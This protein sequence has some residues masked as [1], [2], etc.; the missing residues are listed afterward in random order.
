MFSL[1]KALAS[2]YPQADVRTFVK[3]KALPENTD[4]PIREILA[5]VFDRAALIVFFASTGIAVRS[6]APFL[7]SKATDPAVLVVDEAGKYCIP[8]L[9]GHLGGGNDYAREIAQILHAEPVITTASDLMHKFAID[10]FAK[11]NHLTISSL[12]LAKDLE[13]RIIAGEDVRLF[14]DFPISGQLPDGVTLCKWRETA[15]II[16]SASAAEKDHPI[17]VEQDFFSI[18]TADAQAAVKDAPLSAKPDFFDGTTLSAQTRAKGSLHP[19][20]F[21]DMAA[22]RKESGKNP[23]DNFAEKAPDS[24]AL[25][26]IPHVLDIGI[27]S[28][29]NI[30]EAA[31][32]TAVRNTLREN[33]FFFESI[34]SIASIDLKKEEKGILSFSAKI[35]IAPVFYSAEEL[36]MAEAEGGF[37]ES[38][39]VRQT[40]GV[41]NVCERAAVMRGG[42]L[43]IRKT[44]C[45]GVTVAA[46]IQPALLR[47]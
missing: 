8:I 12:T 26:L 36:S 11:K 29:K 15:Q 39:F 6:I 4:V 47:F 41:G 45:E 3:C 27:G 22:F 16:L 38:A 31:V 34:R 14:S 5:G 40:T 9:S 2:R 13:A 43:V 10:V 21:N 20:F 19:D 30:S 17:A 35:G 7:R 32:E 23:A 28:R 42:R 18:P 37:S 46:A 1:E 25:F 33:G 44:V 24:P